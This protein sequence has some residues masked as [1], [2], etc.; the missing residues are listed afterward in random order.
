MASASGYNHHRFA[1]AVLKKSRKWEPSLIV[2]LNDKHWR[3]ADSP[4][5][6][7]YDGPMRPF[8]LALRA[9]VIPASLIPFLYDITPPVSLVDG[10]LV[11]EIQDFRKSPEVRTRVVMRPA[12]ESLAQTIDVMLERKGEPWDEQLALELESRI[13]AAT[14]APLYLGTNILATRNAVL[15]LGL[16][17]PATPNLSADGSFRSAS[18]LTDEPTSSSERMRKLLRAGERSAPFQPNWSILRH[19]ERME[20]LQRQREREAAARAAMPPQEQLAVGQPVNGATAGPANG[21]PGEGSGEKKK[22]K[23]RPAPAQEGAEAPK[24]SK[25][26]KSAAAA[27][28]G[29]N[30]AANSTK[31]KAEESPESQKKAT[32]TKDETAEEKP[33]PKKKKKKEKAAEAE[34]EAS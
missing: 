31:T 28:A 18:S 5:N 20:S 22:K 15:A 19:K 33:K 26:K 32:K 27:A 14:S 3:F 29:G 24:E 4:M 10:C 9:Q 17:S 6:F 1:R 8:L 34:A 25:K 12:A 16:T 23:K 7:T 13:I 2:Q 11:V 21:A 30:A